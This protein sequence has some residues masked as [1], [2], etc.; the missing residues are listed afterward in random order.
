M[1]ATPLYHTPPTKPD[2]LFKKLVP[3][4]IHI[5]ACKREP[6]ELPDGRVILGPAMRIDLILDMV[7]K[8]GA[9]A[10]S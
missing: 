4:K 9:I 10:L 2:E 7:A 8:P 5:R 3:S 1:P 6:H